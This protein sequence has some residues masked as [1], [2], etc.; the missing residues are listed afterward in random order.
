MKYWLSI[1]SRTTGSISARRVAYWA[2]R[3][4]SGTLIAVAAAVLIVRL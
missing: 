2:F 1:T 3:S 4:S